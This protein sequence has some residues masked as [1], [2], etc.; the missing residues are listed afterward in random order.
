VLLSVKETGI[1]LPQISYGEVLPKL[2]GLQAELGLTPDVFSATDQVNFY[3]VMLCLMLGTASLPHVL[4]RYF[5]T[6]GVREARLSV[7]WSLL[8]IFFLYV[9]APSVAFFAKTEIL[10]AA[11][12]MVHGGAVPDWVMRWQATGFLTR[13]AAQGFSVSPDAVVLMAP[14]AAGFPFIVAGLVGA[15]AL[16]AAMSS[17]D[18]LLLSIANAIVHHGLGQGRPAPAVPGT[19][20]VFLWRS[21]LLVGLAAV[22]AALVAST[23]P[24]DILTLVSWAFSLAAAGLFPALALGIWWKRTTRAGAVAGMA[25]GWGVT[26]AYILGHHLLG[27]QLCFGLKT[28]A[29]GALGIPVAFALTVVVSLLTPAPGQDMRDFVDSLRVPRHSGSKA[30][31]MR[32][33]D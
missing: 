8:F 11:A 7:G 2:A 28:M 22:L 32:R 19:K 13:D 21:R 12:D 27:W 25:G 10:R 23:R 5:A 26:L 20:P 4:A 17:A 15:A 16:A 14:E 29:A 30:T 31:V 6:P 33:R 9:T 3:G 18:G 24:A 1:P